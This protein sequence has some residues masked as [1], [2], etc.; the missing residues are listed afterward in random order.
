MRRFKFFYSNPV[1]ITHSSSHSQKQ[2]K[3]LTAEYTKIPL[4][5]LGHYKFNRKIDYNY[6]VGY[7]EYREHIVSKLT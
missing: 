7:D 4:L 3:Q 1:Q 2:L 5:P 6:N